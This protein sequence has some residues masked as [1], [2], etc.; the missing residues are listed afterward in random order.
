MIKFRARFI[1]TGKG[2]GDEQCVIIHQ[3]HA[4]SKYA[5]VEDEEDGSL[6]Q[7]LLSELKVSPSNDIENDEELIATLA[8][9]IYIAS[10]K[11]HEE[12]DIDQAV[13]EARAIV[14]TVING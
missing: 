4:D 10:K 12:F 7:C 8:T 2:E 3:M 6:F 13:Q 9:Q 14:D 5:I 11:E 1:P